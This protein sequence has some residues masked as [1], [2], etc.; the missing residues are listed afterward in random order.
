MDGLGGAIE[1]TAWRFSF[2]AGDYEDNLLP[3]TFPFFSAW[4]G[5]RLNSVSGWMLGLTSAL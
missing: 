5:D 2:L 4:P 1:V 3:T